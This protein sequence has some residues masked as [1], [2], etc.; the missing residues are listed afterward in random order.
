MVGVAAVEGV[1][2]ELTLGGSDEVDSV[3]G[4]LGDGAGAVGD[5][6]GDGIGVVGGVWTGGTT[7]SLVG[8]VGGVGVGMTDTVE[9]V[10]IVVISV[11][12]TVV[13]DPACLF[14]SSIKLCAA[15]ESS[16]WTACNAVLSSGYTPC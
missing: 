15:S 4:T 3:V 5:G 11:V 1:L 7:K 8:V 14:A 12:V 16:R 2:I 6:D 10:E 9:V 13:L